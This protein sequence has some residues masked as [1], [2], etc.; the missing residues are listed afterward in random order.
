MDSIPVS[1]ARTQA[2]PRAKKTVRIERLLRSNFTWSDRDIG[3]AGRAS[4]ATVGKIRKRLVS[5]GEILPY[6]ENEHSS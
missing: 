2:S 6:V 3:A 4:P 5:A 1:K